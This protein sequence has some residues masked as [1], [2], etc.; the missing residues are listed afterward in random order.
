MSAVANASFFD[1]LDNPDIF[2]CFFI[3]KQTKQP[4]LQGEASIMSPPPVEVFSVQ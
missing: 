3:S 2:C 1:I 4:G